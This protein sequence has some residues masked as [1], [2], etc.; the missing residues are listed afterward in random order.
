MQ[1]TNKNNQTITLSTTPTHF[2]ELNE[3]S[4]AVLDD[5]F[6]CRVN[7]DLLGKALKYTE[8]NETVN[9]IHSLGGFASEYIAELP[10]LSVIKSSYKQSILAQ[11]KILKK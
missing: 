8:T 1:T 7:D 2:D 3:F 9:F 11:N 5:V 6:D 10:P 4:I